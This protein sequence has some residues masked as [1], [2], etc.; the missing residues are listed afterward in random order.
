VAY[1]YAART[2]V[3]RPRGALL[4]VS[5]NV[6]VGA[7]DVES[8]VRL[9]SDR[10]REAGRP[11]PLF[12]LLLQEAYRAGSDVPAQ[13]PSTARIPRRI[14]PAAGERDIEALGAKLRMHYVYVPSMR[15]GAVPGHPGEDRGN[16]ILSSL[17]LQ[18][19]VA[20]ELPVEH[21][22]RVAVMAT[23]HVGGLPVT[24]A[25]VH[26]DTRRP[27]FRGSVFS[28][29]LARKRQAAALLEALGDD[30]IIVGGDFNTLAG[31]REP[32]IRAMER[33]FARV[34]CGSGPTHQSGLSLDY[35]FTTDRS[36]VQ[37]CHRVPDRL[38]SDHHALVARVL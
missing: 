15:N 12:V 5:W 13:Y 22:R 19:V 26:L 1:G 32:A 35:L 10:E 33:R 16:A 30:R 2:N 21:Q 34:D 9:L 24:V 23:L 6:A 28:G 31:P 4:V 20:I 27:L 8:L 29:P 18:D 11:E 17:P 38:H 37:E 25:S 3:E 14:A 36:L 7:G